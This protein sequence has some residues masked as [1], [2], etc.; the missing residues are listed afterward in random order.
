MK[1]EELKKVVRDSYAKI[2]EQSSSCCSSS[3]CGTVNPE[4]IS[5]RIGYTEEELEADRIKLGVGL[6]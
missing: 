4:E 1:E 5:K 6:R 2:A 3:C